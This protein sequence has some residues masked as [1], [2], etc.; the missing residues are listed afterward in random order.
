MPAWRRALGVRADTPGTVLSHC[1][2][3][4]RSRFAQAELIIS[5]GQGNFESL[6]SRQENIFFL[7][8]TKCETLTRE[9]GVPAG[10]LVVKHTLE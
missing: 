4:F 6:S 2:E 10:S 8:Q 3:D 7:F 9:L 1:S 5:K